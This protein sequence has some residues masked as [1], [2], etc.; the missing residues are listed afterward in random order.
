MIILGGQDYQGSNFGDG[1]VLDSVTD[2]LK[3][4]IRPDANSL[5]FFTRYNQSY[6]TNQNTIIAQVFYGT[7]VSIIE[8]SKGSDSVKKL[9]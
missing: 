3:Q 7:S 4:V 9:L 5:K 2:T 6:R 1:W 8:Y